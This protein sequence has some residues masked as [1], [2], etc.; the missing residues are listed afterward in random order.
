MGLV[1]LVP[2]RVLSAAAGRGQVAVAA[3]PPLDL[4]LAAGCAAGQAVELAIRPEDISLGPAADGEPGGT[5]LDRVFLGN[6]IEYQVGIGPDLA[7]RVQTHPRQDFAPGAAVGLR[8]D[9]HQI[10]VFP[11]PAAGAPAQEGDVV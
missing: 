11:P 5:I 2:G 8:F 7:L 4:P 3:G 1:N 9:P 6:L 10:S